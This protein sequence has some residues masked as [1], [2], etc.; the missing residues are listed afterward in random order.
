MLHAPRYSAVNRFEAYCRS[1]A[2]LGIIV[3][4][5]IFACPNLAK[6]GDHSKKVTCDASPDVA[7]RKLTRIANRPRRKK[8]GIVGQRNKK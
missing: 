7:T 4:I 3:T 1:R 2:D 6:G 8:R 5:V